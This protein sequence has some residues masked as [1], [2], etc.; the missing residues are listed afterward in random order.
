MGGL[1]V[2]ISFSAEAEGLSDGFQ[3]ITII[4]LFS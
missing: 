4:F 3:G 1:E 2:A